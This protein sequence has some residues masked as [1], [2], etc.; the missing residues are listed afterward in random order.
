MKVFFAIFPLILLLCANFAAHAENLGEYG[1]ADVEVDRSVLQNLENYQPPPMFGGTAA[2]KVVPPPTLKQAT[3]EIKPPEQPKLTEPNVKDLLNHPVENH[4]VLTLQRPSMKTESSGDPLP[5]PVPAQTTQSD[6]NDKLLPFPDH[7]VETANKAERI[8]PTPPKKPLGLLALSQVDPVRDVPV[9]ARPIERAAH[10]EMG[11]PVTIS[12]PSKAYKPT[13]SKTMPAV[14]SVKVDAK[15]LPDMV[16]LPP[17]QPDNVEKPSIGERLMD[18]ALTRHMVKDKDEV[19][20]AMGIDIPDNPLPVEDMNQFSL[21]FGLGTAVLGQDQKDLLKDQVVARLLKDQSLR[22]EI[23]AYAS[24]TDGSES[25]SRRISLSRALSARSYL[26]ENGI[27]PTRIDVRALSDKTT[28][29][30]KDRI[31][32]AFIGQ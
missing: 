8:P 29:E 13:T 15:P 19:R 23:L 1:K 30:P 26:L 5:V 4:H 28:E 9:A 12:P 6:S 22:L 11:V 20:Q 27:K 16:N 24:R 25:S 21:A 3:Q 7:K 18:D 2:Q 10:E 17:I 14:P 31:D 32:L